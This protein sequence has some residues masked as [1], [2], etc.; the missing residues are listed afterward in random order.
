MKKLAILYT[1][2]AVT[3]AGCK[4]EQSKNGQTASVPLEPAKTVVIKAP[5]GRWF[6]N[7][8]HCSGKLPISGTYDFSVADN[9]LTYI[10]IDD[11]GNWVDDSQNEQA[12][13]AFSDALTAAGKCLGNASMTDFEMVRFL[14]KVTEYWF[15]YS[16]KNQLLLRYNAGT[17]D[18]IVPFDFEKI[19]KLELQ[20]SED[21]LMPLEEVAPKEG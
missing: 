21:V 11:T 19:K 9:T 17:V 20:E 1:A 5:N 13:K 7:P 12:K 16:E 14:G 2:L 18:I 4:T 8:L 3:I 15:A 6:S 10:G